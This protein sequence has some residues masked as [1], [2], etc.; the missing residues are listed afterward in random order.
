MIDKWKKQSITIR[1]LASFLL[2]YHQKLLIAFVM[3]YYLKNYMLMGYHF[4]FENDL[5][6]LL[7]SKR[8]S[9]IGSSH[10]TL[11]KIVSGFP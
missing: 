8:E 9:K 3:I 7:N 5:I 10:S 2:T 11:E 6:L 4:K 1:S